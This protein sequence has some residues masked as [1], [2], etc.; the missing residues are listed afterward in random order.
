MNKKDLTEF[1]DRI[2]AARNFVESPEYTLFSQ[3]VG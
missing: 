3:P 2:E 1:L